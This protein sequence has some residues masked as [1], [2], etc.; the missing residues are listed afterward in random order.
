VIE[1][2]DR[3]VDLGKPALA[4]RALISVRKLH[5]WALQRGMIDMSPV[6]QIE[7]PAEDRRRDRILSPEEIRAV[8]SAAGDLG[9]PYRQFFRMALVLGQRREEIARWRWAEI[10]EAEGV[11]TLASDRTKAGR[12][13]VVPLP[14]LAGEILGEAPRG[15]GGWIF[16][17]LGDRPI[18]GYSAAKTRLDR[19]VART[20]A[21]A[22]ELDVAHWTIHDLRRTVGT[23]LGKL[24]TPR[25]IIARVLNHADH[26]VTGIYDRYEYLT[27]KRHALEVWSEYLEGLVRAQA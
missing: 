10:N 15:P 13:H 21:E 20:R 6:V 14:A 27:E 17:T 18:S 5:N 19:A 1:L 4:N 8:W 26:T 16:T 2:L 11:W 9:Y 25:F 3:I 12:A 24:G 23:G 22:G 7:K